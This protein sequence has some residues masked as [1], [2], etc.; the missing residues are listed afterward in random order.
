MPL[1]A[2]V[3]L[4]LC[5]LAGLGATAFGVSEARARTATTTGQVLDSGETIRDR[6]GARLCKDAT[7]VFPLEEPRYRYT[8]LVRDRCPQDGGPETTTLYYDPDAPANA[9]T[10]KEGVALTGFMLL[11]AAGALLCGL[12]LARRA[13]RA[14]GRRRHDRRAQD[15]E[16]ATHTAAVRIADLHVPSAAEQAAQAD[17]LVASERSPEDAGRPPHAVVHGTDG[18]RVLRG[19]EHAAGP[20]GTLCGIDEDAIVRVRHRFHP[21]GRHA[22]P[23]CVE[24]GPS[25][26]ED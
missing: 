25:R 14:V 10:A 1:V 20:G 17:W 7:V 4:L 16:V 22:C 15:D 6:H 5:A 2:L 23:R 24:A 13:W 26:P 18:S 11:A 12:A 21:D 19:F 3:V 9:E 8:G